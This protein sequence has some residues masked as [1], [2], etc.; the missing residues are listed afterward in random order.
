MCVSHS[1]GII[2]AQSGGGT[3]RET[4][5]LKKKTLACGLQIY[6]VGEV[7]IVRKL[8]IFS[9]NLLPLSRTVLLYGD[10]HSIC[11]LSCSNYD[12]EYHKQRLL[13][14]TDSSPDPK[15]HPYGPEDPRA[16]PS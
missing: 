2:V 16:L 10:N 5:A 9:L 8:H 11:P 13:V 4:K 15:D 1:N 3:P 7:A 6:G 14:P 12:K